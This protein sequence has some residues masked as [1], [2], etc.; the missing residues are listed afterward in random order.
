MMTYRE[1]LSRLTDLRLLMHRASPNERSGCMSSRDRA[2]RFDESTGAYINWDANADGSGCIRTLPDGSIVAFE[3]E[4]PGV[5]WRIW[6]ALP[7]HGH[8][9]VYL[10][11]SDLPI[12]DTPFIDWFEKQPGDIPPLNLSELSM[13]LSRGAKQFHP[14]PFSEAL[15]G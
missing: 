10:D 13:R 5:I 8:M 14:N 1:L 7:Q 15:P 9:R 2:S 4:G 12:V 3:Q 6:S 11:D